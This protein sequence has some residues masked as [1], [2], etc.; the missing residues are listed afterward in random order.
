MRSARDPLVGT[1][2]AFALLAGCRPAVPTPP[3]VGVAYP[4]WSAGF[5]EVAESTL[6]QSWGDTAQLPRFI[7]DTSSVPESTDGMV[8][9]TR[10]LL[11]LP[12]LTVVVGPSASH[13]A[14]AVAPMVNAAS[15]PQIIPTATTKRLDQAGPWTFRLVA[16]DSA[17]GEFLAGQIAKRPGI[18]RVLILFVND[19]YGQGLRTALHEGLTRRGITVTSELP[20][21][22][23]SDVDLLIRN[24]LG[25]RRPD[26]VVG[27]F[28]NPDMLATV[29][30]LHRAGARIPVF[31]TDGGFGPRELHQMVGT[32]PFDMYGVAFWL[33]SSATP[34]GQ[35]FIERY[36]RITGRAPRAEDVLI[37]DAL[38]LAGT[39]AREANGDPRAAR[40]WLLSLGAGR[41]PFAGAGGPIDLHL[42]H[43]RRYHLARFTADSAVDAELP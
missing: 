25:Q 38:V 16:N 19:A 29:R 37:H 28:R 17:Q 8:E 39:A 9:W 43:Q 6:R 21:G 30:A 41:L 1:L 24:E 12:R 18:R 27:A 33:K 3:I 40:L 15:I 23:G 32:M 22:N 11:R 2:L 42:A 31:V 35:A 14:L 13:T 26:A 10:T 20:V 4:A 5:I 7:Y 34:T 36:T